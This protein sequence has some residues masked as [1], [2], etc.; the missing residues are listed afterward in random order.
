MYEFVAKRGCSV[1]PPLERPGDKVGAP[2]ECG[3]SHNTSMDH[4]SSAKQTPGRLVAGRTQEQGSLFLP[5]VEA[6]Y[7]T[8]SRRARKDATPRPAAAV[9]SAKNATR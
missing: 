4:E 5:F 7:V 3:R 9:P 8:F 1:R 2:G 6:A